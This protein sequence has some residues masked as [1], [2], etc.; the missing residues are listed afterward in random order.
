[1]VK[2]TERKEARGGEYRLEVPI[3]APQVEDKETASIAVK[4]LSRD[5]N[6]SSAGHIVELDRQGKAQTAFEFKE[7]PARLSI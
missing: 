6:G 3:D 2:E 5:A 7:L 1:M 4:V